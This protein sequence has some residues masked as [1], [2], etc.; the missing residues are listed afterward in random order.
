[1]PGTVL[2]DAASWRWFTWLLS[3]PMWGVDVNGLACPLH[4]PMAC[5]HQTRGHSFLPSAALSHCA[6][7]G[8]GAFPGGGGVKPPRLDIR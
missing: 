2:G 4:R 7:L 8:D 1:M 3:L 6:A 5:S